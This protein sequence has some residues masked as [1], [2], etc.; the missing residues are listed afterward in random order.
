MKPYLCFLHKESRNNTYFICVLSITFKP[1]DKIMKITCTEQKQ[2]EE[3][4]MSQI[5]ETP[6]FPWEEKNIEQTSDAKNTT[7]ITQEAEMEV[8]MYLE[9]VGGKASVHKVK[10]NV[11]WQERFEPTCGEIHAFLHERSILLSQVITTM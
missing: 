4:A 9:Y 5:A 6:P 8:V 3:C 2:I 1:L 10:D 11:H 7:R